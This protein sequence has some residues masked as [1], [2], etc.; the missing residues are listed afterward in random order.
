MDPVT[1]ALAGGAI[2]RF[3]FRKKHALAVLLIASLAP[4]LDYVTRLWGID[5]FLRYHRGITHGVMALFLAPFFIAFAYG[6]K[7][8]FIYYFSLGFF[9]YFVHLFLDLTN[10]YGTRIL[11]PL[12]WQQYSLDLTF[13]I[14]PYVTLGLAAAVV[15][16][17]FAKKSARKI[18][19][20]ALVLFV[21]YIGIK[22]V[23]HE[24]A[25]GYLRARVD[26]YTYKLSPL[27][28]DFL[29]WWFVADTKDELITGY[30]DMFSGRVYIHKRYR[31]INEED[32]AIRMSRETRLV[33]NFLYF[34]K[35]PYPEAIAREG[36]GV[37]V[38]W[39][40]LTYS[41][42]AG[43]RFVAEVL[44]DRDGKVLESGFKF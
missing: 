8:D 11:S 13:I 36:G 10:Q 20:A 31:A 18:A 3:G 34:A 32:P 29:R 12:D 17:M 23:L 30:A 44:F 28:N 33:K 5:V 27:P 19:V 39:R 26:A 6:L 38:K 24:K 15:A 14:D 16:P 35:Y 37:L 4:D 9:A 40:E 43:D 22:Y 7:R 1:H 41:Y 2:W 42:V 25:E 21:A